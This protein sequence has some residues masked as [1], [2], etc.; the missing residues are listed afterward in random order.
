M[1]EHKSA[2]QVLEQH[3]RDMGTDL[4]GIKLVCIY[5]ICQ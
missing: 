4:N 1:A 2:E 3:I 5:I